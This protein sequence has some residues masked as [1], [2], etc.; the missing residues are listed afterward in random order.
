MRK[1]AF[2][3]LTLFCLLA[4]SARS[5]A[6]DLFQMPPQSQSKASAP[7]SLYADA[8][9]A[10]NE[11]GLRL[12]AAFPADATNVAYSPLAYARANEA[13]VALAAGNSAKPAPSSGKR[14]TE[15]LTTP[16]DPN[17]SNVAPVTS[18][19]TTWLVDK[20]SSQVDE[21]LRATVGA[22][23]LPLDRENRTAA[24]DSING[25][26]AQHTRDAVRKGIAPAQVAG[27]TW[28]VIGSAVHVR[29]GWMTGFARAATQDAPFTTT[30]G[31][32]VNLPTMH[33]A[34]NFAY[35]RDDQ[36]EWLVL[37]LA[38][39]PA[40]EGKPNFALVV[41]L[42]AV[43]SD[44]ARLRTGFTPEALRRRLSA[45]IP[46]KTA[47]EAWEKAEPQSTVIDVRKKWVATY[48]L[49]LVTLSLPKFS[50]RSPPAPAASWET[51]VASRG[52]TLVQPCVLAVDE[53]GVNTA[54]TRVE[55]VTVGPVTVESEEDRLGQ[56][57]TFTANR[58]FLV[59]VVE[60]TT[61]VV[62]A[63]GTVDR[64]GA[65]P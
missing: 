50:L 27:A 5:G 17:E 11:L 51:S 15:F 42:P 55:P 32:A 22:Q 13:A 6:Q 19:T 29:A 18:T 26:V 54:G 28:G 44:V 24:V 65:Q 59:A 46:T 49:K 63:A 48:P 9:D 64:P 33:V 52:A 8:V 57:V 45:A 53:T 34:A 3:S 60:Q 21:H 10:T 31:V 40:E 1:V 36:A 16:A 39:E 62:V 2:A 43:G 20:Y 58:S 41:M 4:P 61:G 35:A 56:P 7:R 12:W 30:D 25:W 23:A 14:L 47:M 38:P 37:P